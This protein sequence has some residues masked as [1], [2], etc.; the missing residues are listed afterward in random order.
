MDFMKKISEISKRVGITA[1][2]TY[3]T[4]ADKSGKLLEEAKMKIAISDKEADIEQIYIGMG[5]TVYDMFVAGEDVGKVFAK[6]CKNID[7]IVSEIEEM[8]KTVLYNKKLK[9]CDNCGEI[10]SLDSSYCDNCG[11]KQKEVKIKNIEKT[12]KEDKKESV[13]RVCP[14]CGLICDANSKFCAKCGYKF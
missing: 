7:K 2:E 9:K 12:K 1:T 14:T 13:E 4:V 5:K 11:D 10:I 3:K 6:E 8:N